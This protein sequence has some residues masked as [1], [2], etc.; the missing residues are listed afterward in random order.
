MV[1]G[2]RGAG[3]GLQDPRCPQ[4]RGEDGSWGRWGVRGGGGGGARGARG[5]RAGAGALAHLGDRAAGGRAPRFDPRAVPARGRGAVSPFTT[6]AMNGR[7]LAY[8]TARAA[9]RAAQRLDVGALIFAIAR[10]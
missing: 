2:Q 10:T 7:L 4:E 8:D 9:F 5:A 3:A 6:P 1:S